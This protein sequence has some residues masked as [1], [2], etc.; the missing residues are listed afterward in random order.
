M[1]LFKYMQMPDVKL[2]LLHSNFRNNLT[3]GKQMKKSK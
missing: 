3:V 2:L 1:Y